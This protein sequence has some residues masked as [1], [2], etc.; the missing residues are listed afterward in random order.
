MRV[1]KAGGAPRLRAA[2]C[3]P[4]GRGL[5][6]AAREQPATVGI[7]PARTVGRVLWGPRDTRTANGR[8]VRLLGSRTRLKPSSADRPHLGWVSVVVAA[9]GAQ[10]TVSTLR[11]PREGFPAPLFPARTLRRIESRYGFPEELSVACQTYRARN[12]FRAFFVIPWP[13]TDQRMPFSSQE[14]DAHTLGSGL[15]LYE[16]CFSRLSGILFEWLLTNVRDVAIWTD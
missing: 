15:H 14:N 4:F 6:D 2:G 3:E 9:S 10:H 11:S 7:G 8:G 16:K 5:S 12:R 13:W 1:P